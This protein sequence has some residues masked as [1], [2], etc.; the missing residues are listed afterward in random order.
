MFFS[1]I[2]I[3]NVNYLQV[4]DASQ[5]LMLG[6][7]IKNTMLGFN[8]QKGFKSN[9]IKIHGFLRCEQVTKDKKT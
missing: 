4:L 6:L 2:H 3:K 5:D 1:C 7:R 9:K 8:S